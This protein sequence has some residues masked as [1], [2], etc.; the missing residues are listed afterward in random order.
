MDGNE[1]KLLDQDDF[2]VDVNVGIEIV[3]VQSDENAEHHQGNA[4]EP[5]IV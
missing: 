5:A 3:E 2:R 1:A 4:G